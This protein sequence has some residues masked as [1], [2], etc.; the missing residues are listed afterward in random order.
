MQRR[1]NSLLDS[2]MLI[3]YVS[4]VSGFKK[5]TLKCGLAAKKLWHHD[6]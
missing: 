2:I 1:M 5:V 3:V 4:V 6:L